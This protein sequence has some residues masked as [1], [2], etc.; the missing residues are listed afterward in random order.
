MGIGEPSLPLRLAVGED[1]GIALRLSSPLLAL[2][3]RLFGFFVVVFV[4]CWWRSWASNEFHWQAI[5]FPSAGGTQKITLESFPPK[6][7]NKIMTAT[8][9]FQHQQY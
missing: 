8:P 4:V 9:C 7:F 6:I 1:C 2:S 5:Q 3:C